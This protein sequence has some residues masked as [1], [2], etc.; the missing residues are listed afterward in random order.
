M[1]GVAKQPRINPGTA[2]ANPDLSGIVSEKDKKRFS[3]LPVSELWHLEHKYD[4][5]I[6]ECFG[7]DRFVL[8][9]SMDGLVILNWRRDG[10]SMKV[11]P[12]DLKE[13]IELLSAFRKERGLFYLNANRSTKIDP[14]LSDYAKVLSDCTIIEIAGK[15]DFTAAT[16]VCMQFLETGK[17]P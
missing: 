14:P 9:G 13:N 10:E 6:Q 16:E 12:V 4:A 17:L 2:L 3:S 8:S 7:A 15:T 5:P 11:R 1:H